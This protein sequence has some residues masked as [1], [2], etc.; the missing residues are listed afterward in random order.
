VGG[1]P[2]LLLATRTTENPQDYAQAID[3]FKRIGV[4]V[5]KIVETK[6]EPEAWAHYQQYRD[7]GVELLERLD[8]VNREHF[9]PALEDGQ[10]AEFDLPEPKVRRFGGGSAIYVYE[11][12]EEWG[13]D[14]Q[15]AING[16]LTESVAVASCSPATTE[17]LMKEISLDVDTSLDLKRPA[18]AVFH[19]Q[20]GN[21]ID[22]IRPWIDYG[23]DVATGKL[24]VEKDEDAESESSDDQQAQ[25]AAIAMQMGFVMPQIQQ[26]LDFT[27]ALKSFSSV[28][29]EDDGVWVT[30]SETHFE[31]LE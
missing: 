8:Q 15:I 7:R 5:E 1:N 11:L 4:Q 18:A 22:A 25:Q 30:H 12:P 23:F 13:I 31:D 28:T 19:F 24:K 14:S 9:I 16:G 26:F 6:V 27:T 3:W 21:M 20:F 29:Y 17:R 10:M 2:M